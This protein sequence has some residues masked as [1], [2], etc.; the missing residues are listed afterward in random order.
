MADNDR[1]RRSQRATQRELDRFGEET[2]NAF[3]ED[4]IIG[5]AV[6]ASTPSENERNNA[7]LK[8][9]LRADAEA[10]P[11]PD[12]SDEELWRRVRGRG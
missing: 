1:L 6:Y 9:A 7:E 2:R 10:D 4:R 3:D 8:E 12:M 11:L 5:G